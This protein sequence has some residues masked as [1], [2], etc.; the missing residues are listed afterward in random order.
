MRPTVLTIDDDPVVRKL[1]NKAVQGLGYISVEVDG[2]LA[3]LHYL[4]EHSVQLILLDI[5]MPVLDGFEVLKKIKKHREWRAIPLLMFSAVSDEK[6]V[7]KALELGATSYILK[8]FRLRTVQEKVVEVLENRPVTYN[9]PKIEK[10]NK[11]LLPD[12][13]MLVT[14]SASIE[15]QFSKLLRRQ[16]IKVL[17]AKGA[18]EGLLLL[19]SSSPDMIIIDKNL[20][21]F[22]GEEFEH[23]VRKNPAW[24]NIPTVGLTGTSG[25]FE[26]VLSP[27]STEQS[28]VKGL[29]NIW[30]AAQS[31]GEQQ[32]HTEKAED[33]NYRLLFM[34]DT[35][36]VIQWMRQEV[37]EVFDFQVAREESELI[38]ELLAWQPDFILFNYQDFHDNV[39]DVIK[40]CQ[41]TVGG[42]SVPYY[43]FSKC[44]IPDDVMHKIKKSAIQDVLCWTDHSTG[45][46]DMLDEKLGVNLVT[47]SINSKIVHLKRKSVD[48]PLAG[49]EMIHRVMKNLKNELHKYILDFSDTQNL[50]FEEMQYLG[51]IVNNKTRLNLKLCVLVTS[52][53]LVNSFRSFEETRSAKIVNSLNEAYDFLH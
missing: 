46:L 29:L 2:G 51:R 26:H 40:K 5:M 22:S 43:L 11:K 39:F 9:A 14:L 3:G 23:K 10:E 35:D 19:Q 24:D 31:E 34:S 42:Q 8:P 47:E 27:S 7:T 48:N 18:I 50:S 52:E 45:F 49:R 44:D 17:H 30:R 25:G 21:V 16:N 36:E 37:L 6:K 12:V 13:V 41:K 32:V 15:D 53:K 28:I 1:V 4:E 33:S 38:G 20:Q